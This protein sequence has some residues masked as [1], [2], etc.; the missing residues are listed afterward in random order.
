MKRYWKSRSCPLC[1]YVIWYTRACG[2]NLHGFKICALFQ[3]WKWQKYPPPQEITTYRRAW[4]LQAIHGCS[5]YWMTA[6]L[7]KTSLEW[8]RVTLEIR[9][10][11][12]GPGCTSIILWYNIVCV[13]CKPVHTALFGIQLCMTKKLAYLMTAYCTPK[14]G[15]TAIDAS[16]Y[17]W[18]VG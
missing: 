2:L 14:D 6:L 15:Y 16:F 3:P 5:A 13:Y 12:Y 10:E 17:K 18:K 1:M 7:S 9:L 4:K 11:S 8:F